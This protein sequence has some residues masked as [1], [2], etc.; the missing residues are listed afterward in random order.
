MS[1]TA[2]APDPKR[3]APYERETSIPGGYRSAVVTAITVVLGFSLLFVRSWAFELPGEWTV[4]SVAAALLL[5][6]AV[7]LELVALWRSLQ[8]KDDQVGEYER[9]L[10][11]F[12]ASLI[13]LLVSLVLAAISYAHNV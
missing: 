8:L 11:W 4:A 12:V 6:S 2:P 9:T 13:V 1:Q 10:R 5:L 3:S 7:V